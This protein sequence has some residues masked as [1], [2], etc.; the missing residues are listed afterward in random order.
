MFEGVCF[1]LHVLTLI[2][3]CYVFFQQ[4][5]FPLFLEHVS[6]FAKNE[7]PNPIFHNQTSQK[8]GSEIS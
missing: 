1:R 6:S 7:G 2:L 8:I 4:K 5:C 3:R